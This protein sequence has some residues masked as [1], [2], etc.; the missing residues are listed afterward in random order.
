MS[1][2]RS[3][4]PGLC[5]KSCQPNRFPTVG[6]LFCMTK[7][8]CCIHYPLYSFNQ[9]GPTAF[10]RSRASLVCILHTAVMGSI[11]LRT[12]SL[13]NINQGV[14]PPPSRKHARGK[15]TLIKYASCCVSYLRVLFILPLLLPGV[16]TLHISTFHAC[17]VATLAW[18]S[19]SFLFRLHIL[20]ALMRCGLP[21]PPEV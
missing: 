15:Y 8:L 14:S 20:F 19:V 18:E 17:R 12:H 2:R 21:H 4:P 3:H 10:L 5:C 16:V 11:R 9:P 7:F 13:Y 1:G 6:E